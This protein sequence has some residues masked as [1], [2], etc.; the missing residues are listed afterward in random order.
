M[1]DAPPARPLAAAVRDLP[2]PTSLLLAPCPSS[3]APPLTPSPLVRPLVRRGPRPRP[4][5][6]RR[7][8]QGQRRR[9]RQRRR[10]GQAGPHVHA[11]LRHLQR[12]GHQ[13]SRGG[14]WG[15]AARLRPPV[16][17]QRPGRQSKGHP[18]NPDPPRPAPCPSRC[19]CKTCVA[20]FALQGNRCI[21][22]A[23]ENMS[24]NAKNGRCQCA[25]GYD[26]NKDKT[27]RLCCFCGSAGRPGGSGRPAHQ[28]ARGDLNLA[29]AASTS[30]LVNWHVPCLSPRCC[31]HA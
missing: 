5:G 17:E 8:R 28:Q 11:P 3:V 9:Q 24:V 26:F 21:K 31:R 16:L 29:A 14:T 12:P 2:P 30:G 20:D 25:A 15:A 10:Q 6:A 1:R 4:A 23:G 22:C 13:V 19:S 7:Q 18:P 27:V